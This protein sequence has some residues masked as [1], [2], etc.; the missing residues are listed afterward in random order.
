MN[1][2]IA[3]HTEKATYTSTNFSKYDRLILILGIM[4][5][6]IFLSVAM[7]KLRTFLVLVLLLTDL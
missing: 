3:L 2:S 6:T 4:K 5:L 1:N 7:L